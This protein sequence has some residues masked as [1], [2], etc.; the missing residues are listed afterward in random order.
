MGSY[1]TQTGKAGLSIK[2][3]KLD[4]NDPFQ[5]ASRYKMPIYNDNRMFLGSYDH[6]MLIT[7]GFKELIESE[8]IPSFD[9]IAGTATA[10][11]APAA[12]VAG[13]LEVPL[14]I[15]GGNEAYIFEQLHIF[16][17]GGDFDGIAST[18]PWAIPFGVSIANEKELPFMYI[19]Q[20]K[21]KHGLKQRIEGIPKEGQQVLL[22]DFHRN[23]S[24]LENAI[25]ALEEKGV[26]VKDSI[27]E[28]ISER[29]KPISIQKK[30]VVVIEDLISTGG[31]SAEAV[32]EVRDAGG[33]ANYC[34]SIFNYGLDKATQAFAVLDP[35]C[36][37]ESI[38]TYDVL[39]EVAK[40]AGYLTEEQIKLLEEWRADPFGWGE[41]H[42][43]PRAE[44]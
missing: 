40:E 14:L 8:Q 26:K 25:E 19:R 4:S 35:K 16:G 3:I 36:E 10:G 31:S 12:S 23:D 17:V 11:I 30:R 20:S 1:G 28:D 29:L 22:V 24:Y 27:S 43:F 37:V 7:G 9:Y 41:K 2:A 21:K 34:L 33:Q 39:L 13:F 32:Q 18:C 44:K 15:M 42:G 6:R 38:L 5:W